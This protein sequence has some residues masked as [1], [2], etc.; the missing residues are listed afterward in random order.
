MWETVG[1]PAAW[2]ASSSGYEREVVPT[3]SHWM[4]LKKGHV[5]VTDSAGCSSP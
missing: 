4:G 1:G 2:P 5:P 3:R